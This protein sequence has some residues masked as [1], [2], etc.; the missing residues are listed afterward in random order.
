MVDPT[1]AQQFGIVIG[2]IATLI[3]AI[4][5]FAVVRGKKETKAGE[6]PSQGALIKAAV[7]KAGQES[8]QERERANRD[9]AEL[10]RLMREMHVLLIELR[11]RL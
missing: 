8:R 10:L 6:G 7:D 1:I 9:R 5:G 4:G 2:A 3:T 11:A